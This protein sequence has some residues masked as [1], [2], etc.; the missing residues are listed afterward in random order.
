MAV[1]YDG[2][3]GGVTTNDPDL[4]LTDDETLVQSSSVNQPVAYM[5]VLSDLIAWHKADPV[6]IDE[7]VRH[8]VVYTYQGNRNPFVDHPEWVVCTFVKNCGI[9]ADG[10][11]SGD[12][13][14]WA[15]GTE[16]SGPED[17]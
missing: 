17:P 14:A 10:F 6:D 5:G 9:F 1:R 2:D 12:L 15:V 11:E 8:E 7:R 4:R 3:T 16:D 13:S